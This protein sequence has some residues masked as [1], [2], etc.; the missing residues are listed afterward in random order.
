VQPHRCK[1]GRKENAD[2]R[3]PAGG[4]RP[5]ERRANIVDLPAI[6][7]DIIDRQPQHF[8]RPSGYD[9][10]S[11]ELHMSARGDTD[12]AAFGEFL[13]RIRLDRLAKPPS[14]RCGRSV[15]AHK[16]LGEEVCDALA[17]NRQGVVALA[18]DG[19]RRL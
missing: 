11:E 15:A 18:Q 16:R 1:R 12:L 7:G 5:I 4:E 19:R 6:A 10:V 17:D 14:T 2:H 13:E 9:E 8:V 3:I